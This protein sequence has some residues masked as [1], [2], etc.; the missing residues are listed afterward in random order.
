[1][2]SRQNQLDGLNHIDTPFLCLRL[3][4]TNLF[5]FLCGRVLAK[6]YVPV[7]CVLVYPVKKKVLG[8]GA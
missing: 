2:R 7:G 1:M 4:Y 8:I 6:A 3:R 5:M